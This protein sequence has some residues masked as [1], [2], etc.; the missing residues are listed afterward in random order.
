[1]KEQDQVPHL[2][3]T[4]VPDIPDFEKGRLSTNLLVAQPSSNPEKKSYRKPLFVKVD[5]QNENTN[6]V[7][8]L[9]SDE[10]FGLM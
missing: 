3:Q 7:I 6:E 5:E 10:D 2:P 8:D 9:D 1:M 4:R